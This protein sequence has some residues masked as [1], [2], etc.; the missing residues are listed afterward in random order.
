MNEVTFEYEK[1][2]TMPRRLAALAGQ[3]RRLDQRDAERLLADG[4]GRIIG[5]PSSTA[6][7]VTDGAD[8]E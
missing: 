5:Q 2:V 3:E 6:S 1:D 4:I 7:P 8:D